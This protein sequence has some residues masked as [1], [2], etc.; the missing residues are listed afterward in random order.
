MLDTTDPIALTLSF[1][2]GTTSPS[3]NTIPSLEITGEIE[4]GGTVTLHD[5][6]DCSGANVGHSLF[7]NEITLSALTTNKTYNF[8][9]KHT[10]SVGNFSCSANA[11]DYELDTTAA[12][13]SIALDGITSPSNETTPTF[14]IT[15]AIETGATVTLHDGAGCGGTEIGIGA[16]SSNKITVSTALTEKTY[17]FYLKHADDVGNVSC[18]ANALPYV[19]DLTDPVVLSIALDDSSTSADTTPTFLI[20]GNDRLQWK[21]N[22]A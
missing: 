1:V 7:E 21:C 2:E 8:R 12:Q 4:S 22:L 14:E 10:D 13:L 5:G 6:A 17:S 18:S 16:P 20:T 19:L 11:L 3:N 9:V 15:G